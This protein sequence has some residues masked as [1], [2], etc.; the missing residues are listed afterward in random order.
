MTVVELP[1]RFAPARRKSVEEV[2]IQRRKIQQAPNVC[3]LL[4]CFPVPAM[5][6]NQERQ[7]VAANQN[8]V[9][10]LGKPAEAMVGLRIGE[11]F[12]CVHSKEEAGG[13]GTSVF[14][15]TCGSAKAILGCW[16]DRIQNVDE[17]RLT[18][19]ALEGWRA[20]DLRVI[21]EPFWIDGEQFT[22]VSLMDITDEK[23]R[24]VLERLFF[25]D[26]LNS[27]GGIHGLMY[28][29]P[30][31]A[32]AETAKMLDLVR[33]QSDELLEQIMAGRDLGAAERGELDVKFAP[34]EVQPFLTEICFL[35]RHQL[36][37]D[38]KTIKLLCEPEAPS[39]VSDELLLRRV[40]G[41]LV[42]NALEASTRGETVTV[43]FDGTPTPVFSVHNEG[44]IPEPV[45]LQIFQRSFST[46][47]ATGRGVGT[48]SVKMLTERYLKGSVTLQSDAGMGTTFAV[49]LPRM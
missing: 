38:G 14:C 15:R 39:I 28:A 26:V 29:F 34:L 17:C 46:K 45:K 40:I 13:C 8:L 5:I 10:L 32:D 49:A 18:C 21:A 22:V 16:T 24:M 37:A 9:T 6:L 2:D 1:T 4:R 41:N 36:I 31:P 25:H 35:Y 19:W 7:I 20:W 12:D 30:E 43:R 44:A 23:R 47:G 27:A 33:S 11:V 48:Y 3:A 42:K